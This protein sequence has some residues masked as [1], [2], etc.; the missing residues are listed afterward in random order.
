M[1]I[2]GPADLPAVLKLRSDPIKKYVLTMLGHPSVEV[3]ITEDQWETIL[4]TSGDW[5]S[6][7][8]PREQKLAVFYTQPLQPTYPMP[9]DAYWVQEVSWDPVTT[10]LDDIFGAES[11]LFCVSPEFKVLA[12]DG[13]L[14]PLGDWKKNWKVKT[15]YGP[16][17]LTI[18]KHD[19]RRLL[20]KRRLVYDSG[21]VEATAN[22]PI[23][24][25]GAQGVR[26]REFG[27]IRS[28]DTLLAARDR[29]AVL[30][31]EVFESSE[32][33]TPRSTRGCYYG[34][35]DGEPVLMH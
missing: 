33:V 29:V 20:P 24:I 26:W 30:S 17:S 28:G 27:E 10:R 34:C 5:I 31:V 35:V 18:K 4:R 32:A 19:N 11:F 6:G 16:G 21:V 14:Q 9:A 8:F 25:P 15:P 3:E 2:I 7:Y 22:H 13:S 23:A 12:K 1:A